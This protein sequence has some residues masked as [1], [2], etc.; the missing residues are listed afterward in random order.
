VSE[1]ERVVL[2]AREHDAERLRKASGRVPLRRLGFSSPPLGQW[3]CAQ[4]NVDA[5]D[6]ADGGFDPADV[7]G[8]GLEI[9][10][11]DQ[12]RVY[13]GQI[14]YQCLDSLESRDK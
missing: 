13:A 11:S 4:L 10:S 6:S 9:E 5:P 2:A 7:A 3:D 14:A 12:V 1:P 8:A